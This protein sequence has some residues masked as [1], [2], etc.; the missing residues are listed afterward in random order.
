MLRTISQD[1]NALYDKAALAAAVFFVLFIAGYLATTTPPFDRLGYLIGRDFVNTWMGARSTLADG[2]A[3]WFDFE[4]YNAALRAMFG[5]GFPEHNWS[6]PPHLLLFTWPLGRLPYLAALALWTVCGLALYLWTTNVALRRRWQLALFAP[7]VAINLFAG[8]TGFFTAALLVGGLGML[9]RRPIL[10]GVL[11]G[12]L[13]V[14]PHLGLLLPI[15]LTID[16]RWTTIAAATATT[17]VL[18][19]A[20]AAW[21][22]ADVFSAYLRDAAPFQ[23][24]VLLESSGMVFAIMQSVFVNAR[25]AGLPISLC[26]LLQAIVSAAAVAATIWAFWTRQDATLARA[27]LLT[28]TM[29]VSPYIFNY[30]MVA[31]TF[32]I[33]AVHDHSKATSLDDRVALAAWSLPVSGM[34]LGLLSIPG[35]PLVTATFAACLVRLMLRGRPLVTDSL[36]PRSSL[37]AG[38]QA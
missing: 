37:G 23:W 14:K 32:A 22:G 15:A 29:L 36:P 17:A 25:M 5:Q 4:A 13:T 30:D 35:A 21:F 10:A 34:L 27:L 31:L 7:A 38:G 8:Q 24:R 18:A 9:D 11:F 6:Y 3:V 28:A 20:T 19:A 12:I 2:P 1:R 33:G 26:W 16:R